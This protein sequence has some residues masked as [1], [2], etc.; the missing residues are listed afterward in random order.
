MTKVPNIVTPLPG[1]RS[2]ALLKQRNDLIP[3]GVYLVQAVTIA[4]SKGAVMTDVDGNSYIDFTSGIGVTSLGHCVDEIVQTISDQAAKLIHSCIHVVNYEPYLELAKRLIEVTP[5]DF[6]KRVIM[7]NS[8]SEAVENAV[9]IVRQATGRPCLISFENSFHGRT[10]MAMTLT[11]KWDP[12]K[13]GYGPFVPG[14][15]MTPFA[16]C[17]RCPFQLEYPGC[18]LHC[19]HHIEKSILKTQVP[20]EQVGAIISEPIQGEG[21]FITPPPDYFK[22][23]KA[24][25]DEHCIKLIIDEIQTGFARTGKLWAIEHWRVEPDLMTMAKAIAS[26]LP[27]S[28]VVAKDELMRDIYP[29]SLGGTFGGNPIACATAVKVLEIIERERIVERSAELGNRLRKRLDEFYD[30]FEIIGEVRGRGPMLAMELVKDRATKK[31]YPEAASKIMKASLASGLL[32]LKAGLYNN[33]IRLHPPLTIEDELLEKG[34]T[35]LEDA[36]RRA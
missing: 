15:Y 2:R 6:K 9:K 34:M 28:A 25:C 36:F 12:Y 13:V 21:G 17:Y 24:L 11:G 7:L 14:V 27:L 8:G 10:Y 18:G 29:G 16:Y 22:E 19:V 26:G 32:T 1:P 20:P 31:P 4:E 3:P 35:I 30:E 23:L 5:G 33:A